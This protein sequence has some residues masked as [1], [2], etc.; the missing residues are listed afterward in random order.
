[1]IETDF[2][3]LYEK[4]NTLNEKWY[5]IEAH[6]NRLWFHSKRL[7]FSDSASEFKN[8]MQ[9]LPSSGLKG[10]RLCIAPDFYLVANAEDYNHYDMLITAEEELYLEVPDTE[11]T[12][13]GIPKCVDFDLGN[14]ELRELQQDALESPDDSFYD[15]Y[16]NYN[17]EKEYQ[18]MLVAD[19]GIFE[20]ALYSFKS[21]EC[22]E[23]KPT[24]QHATYFEDSETYR[25]L[26]P[27]LKRIYIYGKSE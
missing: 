10:V 1:M 25:V 21:K 16:R 27:L 20:L 22:P 26:K 14:F 3:K 4:L 15:K 23:Y 18:G 13:C 19:Y 5:N 17:A 7:W 6:G 24:Y 11:C 12:T 8:F 2:M 9:N